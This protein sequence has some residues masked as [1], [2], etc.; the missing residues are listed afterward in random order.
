LENQLAT[1]VCL[2]TQK[3]DVV[4]PPQLRLE[5]FTL[6]AVDNLDYIPSNTTA[7]G[8][9][10]GKGISLF[11]PLTKTNVEQPREAIKLPAPDTTQC[12]ILPESIKT[13]PAVALKGDTTKVP[14][15]PL[16]NWML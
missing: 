16:E 1:A 4:C 10:H 7:T 6:G 11:Q 13:V 3:E 12:H 9:F 5:L 8:S 15:A 14:K 2:Y